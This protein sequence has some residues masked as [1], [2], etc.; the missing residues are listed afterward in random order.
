M[1]YVGGKFPRG[2]NK[3]EYVEVTSIESEPLADCPFL[4]K[5]FQ[6]ILSVNTSTSLPCAG[7]QTPDAVKIVLDIDTERI[8]VRRN[9]PCVLPPNPEITG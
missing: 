2:I 9:S 7:C 4:R 1:S 8:F 5:T 3:E 6:K